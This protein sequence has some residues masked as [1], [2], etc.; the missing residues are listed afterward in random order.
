MFKPAALKT[1]LLAY[2]IDFLIV[3]GVGCA[4]AMITKSYV[5]GLIMGVQIAAIL[6]ISEARN[7]AT[8]GKKIFRI[9]TTRD[10]RPHSLGVPRNSIRALIHAGGLLL[11]GIGGWVVVASSAADPHKMGRS[12]AERASGS[13][14]VAVPSAAQLHNAAEWAIPHPGLTPESG[15]AVN[16]G[17]TGVS[18]E[19]REPLQQSSP[20]P[21]SPRRAQQ[22]F[23]SGAHA[24]AV[25][26]TLS[27]PLV[28]TPEP[29]EVDQHGPRMMLRFDTGQV[30][31]VDLPAAVILGRNPDPADGTERLIAVQ[32]FERSVSKN[33]ARLDLG[34]SDGWLTD[35]NSTNG[36]EVFDDEGVGALLDKQQ[37]VR[38][39]TGVRIRLGKR[40]FTLAALA[41]TE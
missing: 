33:H 16:D 25:S 13:L 15:Y 10:D 21:V 9:R 7:G 2:L 27:V 39:D 40:H 28:R 32:D 38:I 30:E 29:V 23:G 41:A 20:T 26:G 24:Q 8:L 35:L 14:V 3:I 36:T 5:I 11:G 37:K 1:R 12:W 18:A 22:E 19:E 31:V 4:A 34:T 17:H 6:V